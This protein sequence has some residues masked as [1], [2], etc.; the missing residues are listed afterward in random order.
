MQ[1]RYL[2]NHAFCSISKLEVGKDGKPDV[3]ATS[4]DIDKKRALESQLSFEA[5]GISRNNSR[6]F[7]NINIDPEESKA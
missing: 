1:F 6:E 2:F 5:Q 3:E 7:T 4:P